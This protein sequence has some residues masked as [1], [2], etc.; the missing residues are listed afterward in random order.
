MRIAVLCLPGIGDSLM[1]TPM[2][3]VLRK[4]FPKA[5][6]DLIC[7]FSGVSYCF[8][9]NKNINTIH[10]LSLYNAP[11]INGILEILNLRRNAYEISILTF[12][13]YRR[14][15]HI[16]QFLLGAKKRISHRFTKGLWNEWNFLDTTRVPVNEAVHNV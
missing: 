11:L 13:A 8:K 9:N 12:P 15:Y 1:A 14:E 3:R 2:I 16:V 10:K 6:I 4:K 5:K 7:M